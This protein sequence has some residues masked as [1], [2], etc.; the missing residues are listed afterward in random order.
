MRA[1]NHQQQSIHL[2]F[3]LSAQPF[4]HGLQLGMGNSPS[5]FGQPIA[6]NNTEI[7]QTKGPWPAGYAYKN[8]ASQLFQR[9][10]CLLTSLQS[11]LHLATNLAA[12]L[13]KP[14]CTSPQSLLHLSTNFTATTNRGHVMI[15]ANKVVY[16]IYDFLI[17]HTNEC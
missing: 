4:Y 17:M 3:H 1:Q 2:R 9:F 13:H 14:C 11:S 6:Y 15:K 8:L 7:R 10:L 5:Q 12:P 16:L